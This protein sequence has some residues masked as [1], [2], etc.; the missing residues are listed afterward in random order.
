[1]KNTNKQKEPYVKFRERIYK[2]SKTKIIKWTTD[3]DGDESLF[4][5]CTQTRLTPYMQ[6]QLVREWCQLLPTLHRM[7]YFFFASRMSQQIFEA[8]CQMPNLEIL[9]AGWGGIK[10]LSSISKLKNLK[11]LRLA[12]LPIENIEPLFNLKNLEA[13][14]FDSL[15]RVKSYE[16]LKLLPNLVELGISASIGSAVLSLESIEHLAELKTLRYLDLSKTRIRDKNI[17][18]LGDLKNLETLW[19]PYYYK[20]ADFEYLYHNLPNLR[21]GSPIVVVT[22]QEFC[23]LLK[24]K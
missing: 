4:L 2:E 24:M 6:K 3:Y 12:S 21:E 10:D 23:K 1:M 17:R 9:D 14:Y 5:Q 8:V 18:I 16:G 19:L 11:Y 13:L 7:K 15:K 20:K 22:D